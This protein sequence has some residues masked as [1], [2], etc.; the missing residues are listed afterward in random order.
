MAFRICP[1]GESIRICQRQIAA[2]MAREC[3][4]AE[5]GQHH[6]RQDPEYE[7]DRNADDGAKKGPYLPLTD[8]S[9]SRIGNTGFLLGMRKGKTRGK[10]LPF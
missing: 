9:C 4:L 7:H 1:K 2:G 6:E 10:V 3:L 5:H 8:Q